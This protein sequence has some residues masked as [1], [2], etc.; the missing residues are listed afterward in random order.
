M[1]KKTTTTPPTTAVLK[2]KEDAGLRQRKNGT[3]SADATGETVACAATAR[4]SDLTGTP[5]IIEAL[6]AQCLRRAEKEAD[7]PKSDP[8]W[9][10]FELVR[11]GAPVFKHRFTW[12]MYA[13]WAY[14]AY[15]LL[16]APSLPFLLGAFAVTYL[17]I[18][19]YGAVL[20]V[21]LD[22]PNFLT[23]PVLWEAC[24]EFQWHHFV[25]HEIC[26]RSYPQM[27]RDINLVVGLHFVVAALC[28]SG[29]A[30][31]RVRTVV[32]CGIVN[33]YLLQWAHR[34]AHM[35]PSQR[36][37]VADKLQQWGLLVSEEMHRAHHRTYDTGFP[38]LSGLSDPLMTFL[39]KAV[40]NQWAWLVAFVIMTL[41]GL[42]CLVLA[43]LPAYAAVANAAAQLF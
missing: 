32:C 28:F 14:T 16:T 22:N 10:V 8:N 37:P 38:V 29:L 25:P 21:N 26:V 24:L 42:P 9:M 35:L 34:Q 23:L 17:Y 11:Q 41:A 40:T 31:P 6:N 20:H 2:E 18:E 19:L 13:Y 30:D 33:A 12:L 15:G 43:Y 36:H 1:K 27:A 3:A 5:A 4:L 39:A 7:L